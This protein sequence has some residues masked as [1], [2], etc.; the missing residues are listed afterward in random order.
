MTTKRYRIDQG[1][2]L[3]PILV[4]LE[5][6]PPCLFC[7]E[8]VMRPSSDG[9]LVCGWCDCGV[10]RDGTHWTPAQ[11]HERWEH[12]LAKIEEYCCKEV[13]KI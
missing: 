8:P 11:F 12:R 4:D 9:P 6:P 5:S 3:P 13:V 10:N 1:L 7:G 2:L